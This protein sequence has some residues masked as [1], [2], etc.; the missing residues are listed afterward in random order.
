[1]PKARPGDGTGVPSC[2]V[3]GKQFYITT[4]LNRHVAA[5]RHYGSPPGKRTKAKTKGHVTSPVKTSSSNGQSTSVR[6]K[7]TSPPSSFITVDSTSDS[8]CVDDLAAPSSLVEETPVPTTVES[9]SDCKD[10]G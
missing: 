5:T 3:C 1:M 2:N 8:S 4:S 7:S 9:S 6:S 10:E